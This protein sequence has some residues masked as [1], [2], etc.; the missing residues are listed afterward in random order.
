MGTVTSHRKLAGLR[1]ILATLHQV[2][3]SKKSIGEEEASLSS[4]ALPALVEL[5]GVNSK[6]G[7]WFEDGA[8]NRH[9]AAVV[10]GSGEEWDLAPLIE[11]LKG[12]KVWDEV[13]TRQLDPHKL[14]AE[15]VAGNIKGDTLEKFKIKKNSAPYIKMVNATP[16]SM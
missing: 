6:K 10:Q 5:V 11:H 1:T 2:K 13:S 7:V 4:E 14:A 3:A 9:A 8:G 12:T 16:E 15:I